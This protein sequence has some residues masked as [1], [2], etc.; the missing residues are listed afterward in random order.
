MD[1]ADP[2]A[3]YRHPIDSLVGAEEG[4]HFFGSAEDPSVKG[5]HRLAGNVSIVLLREAKQSLFVV[6]AVQLT[7]FFH[8]VT[9]VLTLSDCELLVD[10]E[11]PHSC[12]V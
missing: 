10:L 5:E 12:Q 2:L 11:G 6:G 4:D 9:R 7:V 8:E 1:A 3:L